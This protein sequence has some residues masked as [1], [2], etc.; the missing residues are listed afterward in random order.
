MA[1]FVSPGSYIRE[2]DQS[3]YTPTNSATTIGVVG[4]ASWGP[5]C[6]SARDKGGGEPVLC[7][8]LNDFITKFGPS[9]GKL[10]G[11]KTAEHPAWYAMSRY[12]REGRLG[13]FARVIGASGACATATLAG[14]TYGSPSGGVKVRA[15][16]KGSLGNQIYLKVSDGSYNNDNWTTS[17]SSRKLTVYMSYAS[18]PNKIEQ[19]EVYDNL[20]MTSS[21]GGPTQELTQEDI[22]RGCKTWEDAIGYFDSTNDNEDDAIADNDELI[23]SYI[24]VDATWASASNPTATNTLSD[25]TFVYAQM[26]YSSDPDAYQS[27]IGNL[28]VTVGND[29]SEGVDETTYIGAGD[30]DNP[31]GIHVFDDA[32]SFVLNVL[33]VPGVSHVDVMNEL[34][35][36]IAT[37]GDCMALI[38]PPFG[39]GV[40]DV[41]KWHN[42]K[43]TTNPGGT[44]Y[45]MPDGSLAVCI[46]EGVTVPQV[47]FNTNM[48]ALYYP[49]IQINDDYTGEDVYVPPSCFA[50]EHYAFTDYV[51]EPWFAAA[52]EN[53]GALTGV[54]R[55]ERKLTLGDR[56]ILYSGG[57][58][59]NP[60]VTFQSTGI[61][62][63]GQRTLQRKP[64]ALDRVNVRRLLLYLRRVIA[65]SIRYLVFEPDDPTMWRQFVNLVTPVLSGVKSRRGIV[66]YRVVMDQTTNTVDLIEQNMAMGKIYIK[67]VKSAEIIVVDFILTA[68]GASFSEA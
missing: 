27:S 40:S 9:T 66:D 61:R 12:F 1:T 41:I 14:G 53:R 47:P 23:S 24:A 51:A 62:I 49:W 20:V 39:L 25:E 43:L 59:V 38:D 26:G 34:L 68:Q 17:Q 48:A 15:R 50:A 35:E 56:D 7:T 42:G 13:Y 5:D 2:I 36:V 30:P 21:K 54:K 28:T 37:R 16:Y 19:I 31:S 60:L 55:A 52:G 58:A 67:P 22:D 10:T 57:N 11:K 45:D 64:S 3:L 44:I 32:E 18:D 33:Y 65:D 8:S 63:W 29:G 4:T 6:S 46:G